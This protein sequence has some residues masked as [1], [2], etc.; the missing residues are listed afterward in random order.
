MN[1]DFAENWYPDCDLNM[2]NFAIQNR[3]KLTKYM[4][5]TKHRSPDQKPIKL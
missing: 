4:L 5:H 1:N 3:G 2:T